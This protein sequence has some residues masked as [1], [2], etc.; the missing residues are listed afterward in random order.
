MIEIK[1]ATESNIPIIEDIL[2]DAV[3]WLD[4]IG[5]PLWTKK[6]TILQYQKSIGK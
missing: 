2:T 3:T 4:S 5:K 6:S 1:R